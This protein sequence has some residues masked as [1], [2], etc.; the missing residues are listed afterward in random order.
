MATIRLECSLCNFNTG[1]I[2]VEAAVAVLNNHSLVHSHQCESSTTTTTTTTSSTTTASSS[3]STTHTYSKDVSSLYFPNEITPQ[4]SFFN[5]VLKELFETVYPH[6]PNKV[7]FREYTRSQQ[8]H[9]WKLRSNCDSM[10]EKVREIKSGD[11][12]NPHL[13]KS[14]IVFVSRKLVPKLVYFIKSWSMRTF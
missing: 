9:R 1:D 8:I 14:H 4:I 3:S 13:K 7:Q 11:T 10:C 5:A 12:S 6:L 2:V